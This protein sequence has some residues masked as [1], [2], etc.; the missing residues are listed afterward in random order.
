MVDDKLYSEFLA[1]LKTKD[2]EYET[3][4]NR[5][6]Q[7]LKEQATNENYYEA[8]TD[9]FKQMEAQ[10]EKEKEADI[11]KYKEQIKQ[12]IGAE[13]AS[14]YYYQKGATAFNLKYD[15]D[16]EEAMAVLLDKKKYQSILSK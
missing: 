1:Y 10:V 5:A 7:Q 3:E 4:T 12:Y 14:R 11:E 9:L 2:F 13:I 15:L 16:I 6:L 8:I